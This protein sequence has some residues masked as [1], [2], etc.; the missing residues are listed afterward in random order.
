MGRDQFIPFKQFW[1]ESDVSPFNPIAIDRL[2]EALGSDR[3]SL[4]E[5]IEAFLEEGPMLVQQLGDG[6]ATRDFVLMRRAA[7]SL[8][9]NA[10]D[11][12]A[13]S[14]AGLCAALEDDLRAG[15][16]PDTPEQRAAL[17]AAQWVDLEPALRALAKDYA[18]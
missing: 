10:R 16:E 8:K 9:S 3:E 5:I 7:H 2:F 4:I 14:L 13:T 1:I 15:D 12:G 17:I 18:Q 6:A 11:F